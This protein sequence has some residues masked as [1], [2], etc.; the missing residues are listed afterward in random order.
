MQ[1]QLLIFYFLQELCLLNRFCDNIN[2]NKSAELFFQLR[3]CYELVLISIIW[4]LLK[5]RK[6]IIKD[7]MIIHI[8]LAFLSISHLCNNCLLENQ[9]WDKVVSK[10]SW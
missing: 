7:G 8:Y 10:V 6:F 3:F 4:A 2:E 1:N 9:M 5:T